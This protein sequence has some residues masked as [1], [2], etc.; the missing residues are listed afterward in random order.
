MFMHDMKK[1]MAALF[2]TG[3]LSASAV[4][5][6]N[7]EQS[8]ADVVVSASGTLDTSGLTFYR[9]LDGPTWNIYPQSG[10]FKAGAGRMDYYQYITTSGG[11]FGPEGGQSTADFSSGDAVYVSAGYLGVPIN[12]ISGA[13]LSGSNTYSGKTIAGLNM[14]PGSYTWSWSS[15]SVVLNISAS[16]VP[17]PSAYA[18]IA[19]VAMLGVM[20]F[21]RRRVG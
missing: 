10:A 7:V 16:A 5:T 14:T 4:V 18:L 17:E 6:I 1:L 20:L 8:G 13:S 2:L 12:F 21:R 19:G 15:D 11:R 9:D 3:V